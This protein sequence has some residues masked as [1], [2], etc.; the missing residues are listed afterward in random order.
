MHAE[1]VNDLAA[2]V[3]RLEASLGNV[4]TEVSTIEERVSGM[5]TRADLWRTVAVAAGAVISAMWLAIQFFAKPY[6]ESLAP[7]VAG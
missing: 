7:H 6:L 2:R 1:F 4:A 3:A 5:P